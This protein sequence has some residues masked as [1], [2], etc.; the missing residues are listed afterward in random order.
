MQQMLDNPDRVQDC[1]QSGDELFFRYGNFLFSISHSEGRNASESGA[2]SFYVYPKSIGLSAAGVGKKFEKEAQPDI[3]MVT[4]HSG[5][6]DD[7]KEK[8]LFR[9]LYSMI[10]NKCTGLDAVFDSILQAK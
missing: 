9:D 5:Q 7:P 6:F 8:T 4:Y 3:L 2:Y 1:Y 10:L